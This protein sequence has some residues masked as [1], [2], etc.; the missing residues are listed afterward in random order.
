MEE[1]ESA[2]KQENTGIGPASACR[3]EIAFTRRE[4][5]SSCAGLTRASIFF[6]KCFYE[7]GWIAGSSP[8]M[9][10]EVSS[11]R[12]RGPIITAGGYGS[13]LSP[14][15]REGRPGRQP[16]QCRAPTCG[17]TKWRSA[18]FPLFPIDTI[19]E[20]CNPNVSGRR[21]RCVTPY[22]THDVPPSSSS[23]MSPSVVIMCFAFEAP[24]SARRIH[25]NPPPGP[26]PR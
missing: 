19:N 12:K 25:I 23:Y 4:W 10:A 1:S 13:R 11:P 2:E 20:N 14:R 7:D 16:V 3:G 17:C 18:Q 5:Y 22:V 24:M 9:T 21:G 8:A 26:R 15:F 6:A